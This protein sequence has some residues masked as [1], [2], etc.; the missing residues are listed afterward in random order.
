V[1]KSG[2]A[3]QAKDDNIIRRMRIASQITKAADAHSEYVILFFHGNTGYANAPV[4][5]VKPAL[6]VLTCTG[7]SCE[8]KGLLLDFFS[9]EDHI[10]SQG[11]VCGLVVVKRH[12][13]RFLSMYL[14]LP[15]TVTF[16]HCYIHLSDSSMTDGVR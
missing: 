5:Y 16:H 3:R 9:S 1:E 10:R 11:T 4:Y 15:V 14:H 13:D 7:A 2:R 8:S 12:W 6:T